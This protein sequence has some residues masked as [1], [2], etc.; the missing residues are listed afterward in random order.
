[1]AVKKYY[2]F[3]K[4]SEMEPYNQMQFSVIPRKLFLGEGYPY[5][6]NVVGSSVNKDFD[7][8]ERKK[9]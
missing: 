5:V 9:E 7:Q 4:A 2:T 1:M 3:S 6:G 8:P